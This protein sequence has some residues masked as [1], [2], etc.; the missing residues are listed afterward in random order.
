MKYFIV[1]LCA[2]LLSCSI[3][4]KSSKNTTKNSPERLKSPYILLISI[5][6]YRHDYTQLYSPE[7]IQKFLTGAAKAK[8][9]RPSFPSKTFPNHYSIITGLT[10]DN[11][12]IVANHFYAPDLKLEYKLS[13]RDM[14][15]N[16]RFYE[17]TPFWNL[18]T[19]NGLNSASYF[20][21]GSEAA[22]NGKFPTFWET[23]S[24]EATHEEKVSGI[25][26]WLKLPEEIRPHF[27]T[28]YFHDVDSAGHNFGPISPETRL[29]V[30]KVDATL[31]KLFDQIKTLNLPINVIIVSDHGMSAVDQ[32]NPLYLED[33]YGDQFPDLKENFKIIGSGPIVHFYYKGK[34]S[35]KEKMLNMLVHSFNS[36]RVKAKAFKR[37]DIPSQYKLNKNIR[38]GDAII[39]AD[40]GKF[41]G[42]KTNRISEGNHGYDNFN[43]DMHGIFYALGPNVNP[44]TLPTIDNTSIY[45]FMAKILDLNMTS[46]N[47]GQL[48]YLL[49]ILKK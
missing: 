44:L 20:W 31:G 40:N 22:I 27:L 35:K 47:D 5:D 34:E 39:I 37:G 36:K 25:M 11:H 29:A 17:G 10:P 12:G 28:L 42:Q 8:S 1:L 18:C 4:E 48:R 45:N 32:H 49:P 43:K 13:D 21:P 24:M 46:T 3:A 15:R 7:N 2:S 9:L 6:G 19:D 30:E 26:K 16:P 41:V 14:V 33:I 38:I 23:F